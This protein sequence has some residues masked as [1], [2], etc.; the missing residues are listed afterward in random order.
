MKLKTLFIAGCFLTTCGALGAAELSSAASTHINGTFTVHEWGTFTTVSGSDGS[1]L[2]GL[3]VEEERLPNFVHSHNGFAPAD[4][5][6]SRPVRN[7]TVKMETPVIYFYSDRERAVHVDVRF[8]GGSI[9]QWYPGRS[10]GEML[11]PLPWSHPT[12]ETV[13]ALPPVDF[14]RGFDGSVQWKVTVLA[15]D[16]VEKI[17]APA[18]WE[19]PQWPRARV[20]GAN[21]I[22]SLPEFVVSRRADLPDSAPVVEGF[23]FYRGVGNFSVP[24]TASIGADDTLVLRNT[25]DAE[26]PFV[27]IYDNRE[28]VGGRYAWSGPLAAGKSVDV[29]WAK[30]HFGP[31]RTKALVEPLKAAGLSEDETRAMLAT[32]KESYFER[33]GLRVFWIVPRAF[34]DRILPLTITP[35]PDKLERVLVGR[36]EVLTP[37]F[38]RELVRGFSTDGGKQWTNDRY[39]RAYRERARQLGVVLPATPP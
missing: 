17:N 1:L 16:S 28:K 12:I 6:W 29:S 22:K 19:T 26:I 36:S 7:V 23:L 18:S 27:W 37:A 3:E 5:G 4:K 25:G 24:L 13:R 2:S 31:D 34:T 35:K 10:G 38:E 21:L 39:F 15:P 33:P 11:P 14:A 8:D 30:I 9:S 32:W 20:H